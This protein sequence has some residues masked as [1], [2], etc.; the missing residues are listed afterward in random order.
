MIEVCCTYSIGGL[1]SLRQE[2]F[3]GDHTTVRVNVEELW[4][5]VVSNNAVLQFILNGKGEKNFE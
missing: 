3:D 4:S 2:T 5:K 1:S